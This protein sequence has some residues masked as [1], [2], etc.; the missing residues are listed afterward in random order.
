MILM[1]EKDKQ[2]ESGDM[3]AGLI[4]CGVIYTIGYIVGRSI[5]N[6]RIDAAYNKGV[7]DAFNY[8]I[9]KIR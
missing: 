7:V 3:I 2:K 5:P 9:T 6:T 1:E 4:V 8:N